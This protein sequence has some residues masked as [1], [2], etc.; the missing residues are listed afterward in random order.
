MNEIEILKFMGS[1]GFMFKRSEI[2]PA[3]EYLKKMRKNDKVLAIYQDKKLHAII[4]FSITN[5]EHKFLKKSTWEFLE[6]NPSGQAIIIDYLA[7]KQFDYDLRNEIRSYFCVKHPQFE[8]ALWKRFRKPFDK[9]VKVYK[10]K[11]LCTQ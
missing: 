7:C 10:E 5:E 3:I 11:Q 6:S 8:Y 9:V 2:V 1:C 4:I